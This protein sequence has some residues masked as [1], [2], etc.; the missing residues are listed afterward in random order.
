M[1]EIKYVMWL[2][3]S[4]YASSFT[5]LTSYLLIAASRNESSFVTWLL[6]FICYYAKT[7]RTIANHEK[8]S[9][10]SYIFEIL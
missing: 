4:F 3:E 10:I 5:G 2:S 7:R 1:Q 9:Y 6:P 8:F